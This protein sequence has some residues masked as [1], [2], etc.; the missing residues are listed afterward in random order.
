MDKI[1]LCLPELSIECQGLEYCL[2]GDIY[3]LGGMLEAID[4]M[5]QGLV[6]RAYRFSMVCKLT[7]IALDFAKRYGC[8]VLSFHGGGYKL[9]VTVSA[10]T[11]HVRTLATYV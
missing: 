9:L 6:E 3:G 7:E 2:P 4:Q 1:S 8:P 11:A 5:K 10:A